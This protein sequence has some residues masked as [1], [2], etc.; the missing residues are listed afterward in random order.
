MALTEASLLP[1]RVGTIVELYAAHHNWAAVKESWHEERLHERGSRGSAQGVFRILKRRLQAGGEMLPNISTLNDLVQSC[2]SS[3]SKAQLF[4]FYLTRE[5]NLFRFVLHEVLRGQ[6]LDR[7]R[8]T[9][10]TESISALLDR[11][12]YRD[13]SS[14]EYAESTQ[15]RW[16]QGFRSV[17]RDIG[18][19]QGPYDDY[20]SVPSV[21]TPAAHVGAL[22]SWKERGRGWIDHPTGWMY[23]FQPSLYRDALLESLQSTGWWRTDQLRGQRVVMPAEDG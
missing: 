12:S 15:H 6:G 16:A 23:L 4:Y 7:E 19:L 5:D 20:G 17:M 11:F 18:V 3:Q 21:E 22:Y 14:L 8:W 2:Q 1:D 13:G 9:L 10:R